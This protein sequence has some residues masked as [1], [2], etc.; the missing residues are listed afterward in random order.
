MPTQ[1]AVMADGTVRARGPFQ[2]SSCCRR[3]DK[4][5]TR[6]GRV[7]AGPPHGKEHVKKWCASL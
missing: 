5:M 7:A 2:A 1:I 6:V 4:G 3:F